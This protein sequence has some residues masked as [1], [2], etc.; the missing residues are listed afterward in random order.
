MST[1]FCSFCN[2]LQIDYTSQKKSGKGR[3][4]RVRSID[5]DQIALL[6]KTFLTMINADPQLLFDVY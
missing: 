4:E 6:I 1:Y 2:Q 3:G 5:E